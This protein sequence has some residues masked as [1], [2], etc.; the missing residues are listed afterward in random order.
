MY[1][2]K[3]ISQDAI[4]LDLKASTKEDLIEEL[5]DAL[6]AAGSVVEKKTA[7]KAVFEREK[8]MSTG[9]ADGIA[10]PHA[11]LEELEHIIAA[12]GIK[13]E[14][15]DF[16]ALDEQ[17]SYIFILTLSPAA[18]SGPHIQFLAEISR[19]LNEKTIRDQVLAAK[20]EE[21]VYNAIVAAEQNGD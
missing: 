18:R 20:T 15:L 5:V 21:Q 10:I 13:K 19:V 1:F 3:A 7:L 9:M 14:G 4:L 8:K 16:D 2:R 6:V 17:P 11:K 12:I